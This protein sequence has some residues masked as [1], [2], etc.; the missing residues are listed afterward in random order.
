MGITATLTQRSQHWERRVLQ[1]VLAV[2]VCAMATTVHARDHESRTVF[3]DSHIVGQASLQVLFWDVLDATLRAPNGEYDPTRPFALTLSY[4][5][6]FNSDK[7]VEASIEEMATHPRSSAQSLER[8]EASLRTIFPDVE[9]GDELTG[10]KNARGHT[11]FFFG[12]VRIGE[13]QDA[14]FTQ[15]FFDIW[16]GETTSRPDFRDALLGRV[17]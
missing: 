14:A 1:T 10:I 4:R 6:R 17:L 5:R 7:L 13:V 15:A 16:L 3:P 8:W 9:S 2:V 12:D 11:E